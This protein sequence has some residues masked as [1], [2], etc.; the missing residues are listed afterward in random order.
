MLLRVVLGL[1]FCRN[2]LSLVLSAATPHRGS[3][4]ESV[5]LVQRAEPNWV[6]GAD[7]NSYKAIMSNWDATCQF[8]GICHLPLADVALQYNLQ[9][10][11]STSF[12]DHDLYEFGVYTGLGIGEKSQ[13]FKK[14]L[15]PHAA[16]R[17][18]WGFDSFE[19]VPRSEDNPSDG[20]FDV[21]KMNFSTDWLDMERILENVGFSNATLI[22]GFYNETLNAELIEK[23]GMKPA[24]WV[25][26]DCDL[27]IS[28]YQALDWMFKNR[29][30][31]SGTR[32]YYDDIL[33]LPLNGYQMQAHTEITNKYNVVWKA[34]LQH[35]HWVEQKKTVTYFYEVVS[36]TDLQGEE[37]SDP[38]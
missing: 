8:S 32:V 26:I 12:H 36:Y 9:F 27:Y 18:V 6:S 24:W 33:P 11:G 19:G 29:L 14:R 31:R 15:G 21:R 2:F 3:T 23:H 4:V 13:F 28:S 30:M 20:L 35:S 37:V 22:K 7:D 1:T 10:S 34:L 25:N 16:P 38:L 17:H 5:S